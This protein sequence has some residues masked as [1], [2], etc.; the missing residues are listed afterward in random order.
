MNIARLAC[1]TA[2]LSLLPWIALA[3]GP[4]P[5]PP[6][7]PPM[8]PGIA[9]EAGPP[10]TGTARLAG[11]VVSL[12][13]GR[14]IRRA[15]VRASSTELREGRMVSTDAEGR[16]EL[17]DLP[18]GR[19]SLFV[20]KGG[21]VSLEYGQRR[22]F[23]DGKRIELADKQAIDKIEIALPRAAAIAG[24]VVDE[25]GDP[26]VGARVT[27]MRYRFSNGQRRLTPAGNSDTTDDLGQFRLHGLAPGDYYVV[28]NPTVT[29]FATISGDKSGYTQTY[30]P[31]ALSAAEATRVTLGV[32]Q[33]AQSIVIGVAPTRLVAVSGTASNSQGQPIR[34]GIVR[35]E[36]TGTGPM[37]SLPGVIR[38]DGTFTVSSV[39]PG[40]YR[41]MVQALRQTFEEI[42]AT[43]SSSVSET[44]QTRIVVGSE[45]VA[46]LAL[47]TS[48]GSTLR[49]QVRWDGGVAP[50]GTGGSSGTVGAF[51]PTDPGTPFGMAAGTV[52]DDGTFEIRNVHGTRLLRAGGF[53]KGW[54]LKS[55]TLNGRDITDAPID[56]AAD[57]SG[58]EV[59]LTQISA[60][61]S[62]TVQSAKGATISDYV[63]VLFP[64]ESD[65]WGWQ[66]RFVRVVRPDQ[67]GRFTIPGVPEASYLAVALE[68]MEPGEEGNP[69]FLE[70]LKPLATRVSVAE[71]EKKTLTLKLSA[72]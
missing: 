44:A 68:Y 46:G 37:T 16:W 38:P 11:R 40:E 55:I 52:R 7:P 45:D 47:V 15:V 29:T 4:P 66:S 5:P 21:F 23:E 14:A 8:Q 26:M 56:V 65:K 20:S 36:T 6:P 61:I 3:Q 72:Q 67:T 58:I 70:K 32:G 60:E 51:D 25:F 57:V 64:S 43:G 69:E 49:G 18:S 13:T 53:P 28:A 2:A 41:V 30:Y 17:R 1:T 19:I 34:A 35:L 39:V 22:P 33:E 12:D 59:H 10:K 24:R 48:S 27:T 31:N 71:G 62:G 54:N 50:T 9:R 63:V 42:A